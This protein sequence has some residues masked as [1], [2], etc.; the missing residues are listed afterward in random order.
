[1]KLLVA[2]DGSEESRHALAYATDIADATDGS[3]VLVHAVDPSAYDRGGTE[4]VETPAD[5]DRRLALESVED[6]ERRGVALLDAAAALARTLGRDVETEL[7]YGDPVA[8]VTEYA[9]AE[10]VDTIYVGHRGRSERTDRL[11]GSVAKALVEDA[12]VPVTVVR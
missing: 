7:V 11:F 8:A 5:A 2:I 9:E 4:P 1:M 12:P 6:A 10:S 3:V